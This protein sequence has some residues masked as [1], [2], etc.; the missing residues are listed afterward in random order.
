MPHAG[1]EIPAPFA[2]G[3]VSPWLARRDA[4]W[5]IDRL[6]DFGAAL[7]ATVV[8]TSISRTV[9]DVNRDPHGG[10]LYPGQATTELCPTTTFDG[11]PLYRP[12]AAP[13]SVAIAQRRETYHAPYHAALAREIKRLRAQHAAIV[14]Y[15]CHS[16]RSRI[17]RLFQGDL[18]NF[19]LG[20]YDGASCSAA[21]TASVE[22]ICDRT[23]FS[24]ITN[25]RFKGGYIT[26]H[27]GQPSQG[28]H[29]LQMELACRGYMSEVPGPVEPG[30]WP[31]HYDPGGA[32]SMRQAL[33]EIL[34][35]CL[36][37]A[38]SV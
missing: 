23:E 28:V 9:I 22:S 33:N 4:D 17:P 7:G 37:F 30:S 5:W 24:H 27:Y 14:V 12:G 36:E 13:N 19:N 16:I 34:N 20:T 25:G 15:D 3:L 32:A 26:R 29:A 6:Y 11:E 18:P 21:L 35:A 8:R 38:H 10:S 2:D 1:V 31:P